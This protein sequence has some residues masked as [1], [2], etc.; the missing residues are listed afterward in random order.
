MQTEGD[1]WGTN[2]LSGLAGAIA[3]TIAQMSI[4]DMFF[5]HQ[6]GTANGIYIVMVNIGAFLAV[7][8]AGFSAAS[9]GWRW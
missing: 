5:V 3:E 7:V 8:P 9:Q 1:L 6:R 4:A 2:L